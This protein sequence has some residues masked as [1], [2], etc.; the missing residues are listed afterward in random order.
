M[1]EKE[2]SGKGDESCT[3]IMRSLMKTCQSDYS[4]LSTVSNTKSMLSHYCNEKDEG[5]CTTSPI[6]KWFKEEFSSAGKSQLSL[7]E[8]LTSTSEC[9]KKEKE[10]PV[11]NMRSLVAEYQIKTHLI[12]DEFMRK[13]NPFENMKKLKIA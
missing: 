12:V 13:I 3:E 5:S 6:N 10:V 2:K 9:L 11:I 7:M 8:Q 1:Y 4:K